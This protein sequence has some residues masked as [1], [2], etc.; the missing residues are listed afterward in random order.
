MVAA[1]SDP[2]IQARSHSTHSKRDDTINTFPERAPVRINPVEQAYLTISSWNYYRVACGCFHVLFHASM[3]VRT[4]SKKIAT[5]PSTGFLRLT[6]SCGKLTQ[7][8]G[9][10]LKLQQLQTIEF[11]WRKRNKCQPSVLISHT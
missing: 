6:L 1:S 2:P 9:S 10:T 5:K 4:N 11:Q 7:L 3:V 8:K